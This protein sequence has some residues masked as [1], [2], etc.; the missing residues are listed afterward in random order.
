MLGDVS[1]DVL[2]GPNLPTPDFAIGFWQS[3]RY[4]VQI[5]NSEIRQ[6]RPAR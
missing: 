4:E 5:V 6:W 1:D 2:D 3:W